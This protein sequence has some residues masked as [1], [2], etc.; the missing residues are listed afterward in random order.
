MPGVSLV[1]GATPH[2]S[3]INIRGFSANGTYGTDHKV[4]VQLDGASS[5]AEELYRISGQMFTDP[6]LYREV[7]VI[8]GMVGSFEFGTGAF[9]GVV[10]RV[11]AAF[12]P[13]PSSAW[14]SRT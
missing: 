2:G 12:W 11:T 4:L 9:G 7:E 14:G 5:G 13:G 6:A 1:N 8:R 10:R 3:G